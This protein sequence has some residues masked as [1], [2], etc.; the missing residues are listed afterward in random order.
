MC[1]ALRIV[2]FVILLLLAA[3][4]LAPAAGLA[5]AV[6]MQTAPLELGLSGLGALSQWVFPTNVLSLC[7]LCGGYAALLTA[8]VLWCIGSATRRSRARRYERQLG[9]LKTKLLERDEEVQRLRE[10][11]RSGDTTEPPPPPLFAVDEPSETEEP[12]VA[13]EA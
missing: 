10:R 12:N 5:Y 2:R 8:I 7:V 3:V 4:L 1:G 13:V 9:L 11:L 6:S